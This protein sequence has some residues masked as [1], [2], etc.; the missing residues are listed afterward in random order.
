MLSSDK[1]HEH[2]LV[3]R[4]KQLWIKNPGK[5]GRKYSLALEGISYVISRMMFTCITCKISNKWLFQWWPRSLPFQSCVTFSCWELPTLLR[6]HL[7]AD[8][9][10]SFLDTGMLSETG[11]D[12]YQCCQ[13]V[14]SAEKDA[15]QLVLGQCVCSPVALVGPGNDQGKC[16]FWPVARS[17]CFPESM[18]P[19][20]LW[21]MWKSQQHLYV[22]QQQHL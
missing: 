6:G 11:P 13:L 10:Q 14:C 8:F 1:P 9:I 2:S 21:L 16:W 18:E 19:W 17:H 20:S 7:Q 3:L 5:S 12:G 15:D 4:K 22:S